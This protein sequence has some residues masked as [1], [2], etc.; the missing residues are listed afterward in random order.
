[1]DRVNARVTRAGDAD[2]DFIAA[3]DILLFSLACADEWFPIF[4]LG[5]ILTA[6]ISGD[7][8]AHQSASK[9]SSFAAQMKSFSV[10]PSAS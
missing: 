4:S 7:E 9:A 2:L 3:G 6:K 10:I 8:C 1:M 5:Q